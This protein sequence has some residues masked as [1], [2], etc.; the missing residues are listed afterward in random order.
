M[1]RSRWFL[2]IL[3]FKLDVMQ[4]DKSKLV[5]YAMNGGLF[6]GLFWVVKYLMVMG[7]GQSSALNVISSLLSLGTPLLLVYFLV[8]Y[9]VKLPNNEMGFWH[10]VQFT[11]L[12]FF[13][14]SILEAVIVFIH[15][16]WID[17]TYIGKLYSEMTKTIEAVDLSKKM[18]ESLK[19]QPLP[20]SINYILSNVVFANIFIGMVLSL[21]AVPFVNLY[22]FR[23]FKSNRTQ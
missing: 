15:I 1:M 2:L 18:V 8:T 20:S 6:L 9:K 7:G 16:T 5:N 19:N 13:F 10:G 4:E 23:N 11:I 22:Y 3:Q 14:A 12:L 17:T 21:I